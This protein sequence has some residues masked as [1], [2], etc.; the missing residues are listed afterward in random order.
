M[1]KKQIDKLIKAGKF[2]KV[3]YEVFKVEVVYY[4][5]FR[6]TLHVGVSANLFQIILRDQIVFGEDYFQYIGEL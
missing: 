5:K 4:D 6:D 3:I 1:T 2:Q